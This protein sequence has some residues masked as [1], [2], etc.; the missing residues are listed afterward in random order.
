MRPLDNEKGLGAA[1]PKP[2]TAAYEATAKPAYSSR[3]LSGKRESGH[4]RPCS[5]EAVHRRSRMR[6]TAYKA[7]DGRIW[8][9]TGKRAWVLDMLVSANNCVTQ[10][11]CL[12]WHT[13]LGGTIHA[14][15]QDGLLIGTEIEGEFRHARY[16]LCSSHGL[17][18]VQ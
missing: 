10:H 5:A 13:R 3:K 7:S 17:R 1:T 9:Y 12:P 14:F 15:R 6:K 2:Q 11:D 16:R 18:G 8:R 4:K